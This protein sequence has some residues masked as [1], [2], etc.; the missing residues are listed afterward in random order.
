[1]AGQ[2]NMQNLSPSYK[3]VLTR[4]QVFIRKYYVNRIIHGII[5]STVVAV[6][7]FLGLLLV[8]E[9]TKSHASFRE[10]AFKIA[11]LVTF[12]FVIVLV[13]IPVFKLLGITRGMS[14]KSAEKL[15]RNTFPELQDTLLNLIELAESNLVVKDTS[16]ILAS[17]EE[18]EERLRWYRFERAVPYKKLIKPAIFFV[19]VIAIGLSLWSIWPDFVSTGYTRTIHFKQEFELKMKLQFTVINDSLSVGMGGDLEIKVSGNMPLV[20]SDVYLNIGASLYQMKAK[21]SFYV[22]SVEAINGPFYFSLRYDGFE[23]KLYYVEVIPIP[24]LLNMEIVVKPPAYTGL[25]IKRQ[26]NSGDLI[27][28]EGSA[29]NWNI[30]QQHADLV[31]LIFGEDSMRAETEGATQNFSKV[32]YQDV[33]YELFLKSRKL[34]EPATFK[35]NIEVIR[36]GFPGIIANQIVDS[37]FTQQVYIQANIQDDY[38]FSALVFYVF[39]ADEGVMVFQ[40][41]IAVNGSSSFQKIYYALDLSK[42]A[43]AGNDYEYFLSV[44]DNDH[45]NG[46]KRTDSRK[47]RIRVETAEEIWDSNR[48]KGID[49]GDKMEES[50]DLV[51]QLGEKLDEL[52]SSQLVENKDEWEIKSKVDEISEMKDLL[53]EMIENIRLDNQEINLADKFSSE[54]RDE[55]LRKQEEIEELFENL[56]DD[57]LRKLFEEFEKLAEEMNQKDKLEKTE[58][59]KMSLENLEQQLDINLELLRKLEL[60]KQIYDLANQMKKLGEDVKQRKD[61]SGI[62]EAIEEFEKLEEK[63]EEQLEKNSELNKPHELS[64]FE[65]ERMEI[66]EKLSDAESGKKEKDKKKSMQDA[67]EKMEDLGRKMQDMMA[68]GGQ[69]GAAV[70]LELLRQ[71]ARELND[72]SFRQEELLNNIDAVNAR[73]IIFYDVGVEQRDMELKFGV[74]KDSL[75]S[76]GYKQPMIAA[77]LNQEVFHVETSLRNLFR[78]VQEG[79]V[80][81]V[82]YEQQKVMTGA[83]ELAVRIDELVENIQ[84]MSGQG[85]GEQSFTDSKPK[86]GADQIGEMRDKQQSLKEELK[87][88]IQKMKEGTEGS[89]GKKELARMLSEREMLRQQLEQLRNSGLLGDNARQKLD[90]IKNMMEEVEKDLI[91]DRVSDHTISKEEWIQTRLLEAETAEKE[92]EKENKREATEFRGDFDPAEIPGWEEIEKDQ[93]QQTD[94]MK[95]NEFKLKEYYRIKYQEY[96]KRIKKGKK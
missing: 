66:K 78:S 22:H 64:S 2:V 30:F 28:A 26:I 53:E 69:G 68:G 8:N 91:Y 23:S 59:L 82:R 5:I 76:L 19:T 63:F 20:D 47:F 32:L 11:A 65:E 54:K 87:G 56:L 18:R 55:I 17:I 25:E 3:K 36:D 15:I 81:Q 51:I 37:I 71:L 43:V 92:R 38:G 86:E 74:I 60:E 41:S 31:T 88:M 13:F 14:E 9:I 46:P 4:L 62:E 95:Y 85:E 96:L 75:R 39:S 10:P 16:L 35:Y 34:R 27:M 24:E 90:D 21:E 79:R 44:W 42:V 33:E 70:D 83:N 1:M 77:L 94:L 93:K 7:F 49:L 45:V 29:V 58:E 80:S 40:D 52:V 50:Q 61:S 57:E 73:N 12:G 67:G 84:A 6:I 89:G 72:F 48:E